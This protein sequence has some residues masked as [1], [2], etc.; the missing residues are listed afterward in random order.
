MSSPHTPRGKHPSEALVFFLVI[1]AV[2]ALVAIVATV[3]QVRSDGY[4]SVETR[5][6][7]PPAHRQR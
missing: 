5:P 4:R 2:L 7:T 1:L 3:L 6:G